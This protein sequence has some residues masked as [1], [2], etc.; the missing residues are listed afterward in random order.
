[1]ADTLY[2]GRMVIQSLIRS[3]G[4]RMKTLC[5]QMVVVPIG[6]RYVL[7]KGSKGKPDIYGIVYIGT[8]TKLTRTGSIIPKV[9]RFPSSP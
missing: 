4:R 1:M 3:I 5:D 8:W 6:Q 9:T 2:I 7:M